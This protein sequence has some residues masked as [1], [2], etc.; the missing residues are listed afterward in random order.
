MKTMKMKLFLLAAAAGLAF[1]SCKKDSET[2][3]TFND[4][5][6][7]AY[8]QNQADSEADDVS[9]LE[10]Q[11]MEANDSKINGRI[12]T[13][14]VVVPFDTANCAQV[15]I[16]PKGSNPTG[17]I[18]INFGSTGCLCKDGRRRKGKITS[19]FTDRIRTQG[20]VINT[21]YENYGVTRRGSSDFVMFDNSSTKKTTTTSAPAEI[22]DNAI[23]GITREVNMKMMLPAGSTFSYTG[24]RQ[25][26]WDLGQ[27]A[28]RW[29]NVYTTK[30]GS[31]QSGVDRKGRNYTMTV[32]TDVVRKAECAYAGF[33]KP[34]SGQIT[35]QHDSKTKVVNFGDGSTCDN[36]V[37]VSISGKRRKMRW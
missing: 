13:D 14:S 37:D 28:N 23:L 8:D 18:T 21:S 31:S 15:T 35:I 1:T 36:E 10:N 30:A 11:I 24:S 9:N 32:D 17:T 22:S 26:V 12:A 5:Q 19:V 16:V 3:D 29:D 20:A 25:M 4:D 34:V 2:P 27:L 7:V 6:I 33:Y